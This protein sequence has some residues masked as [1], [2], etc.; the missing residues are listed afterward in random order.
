MENY[1]KQ[2]IDA[3]VRVT[4]IGALATVNPNNLEEAKVLLRLIASQVE[5]V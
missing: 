4:V 1:K 2:Y 5:K 3:I